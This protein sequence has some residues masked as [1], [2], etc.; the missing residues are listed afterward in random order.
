M[1]MFAAVGTTTTEPDAAVDCAAVIPAWSP[2]EKMAQEAMRRMFMEVSVKG[3]D[4]RARS[5]PMIGVL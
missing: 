1:E 5:T 2:S 4:A 3:G